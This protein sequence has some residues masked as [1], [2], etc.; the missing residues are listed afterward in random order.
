LIL[1][2]T[3]AKNEIP[4]HGVLIDRRTGAEVGP[5]VP[6]DPRDWPYGTIEPSEIL[7]KY[8]DLWKF[9]EM[10]ENSALYFSRQDRFDDPFEGRFT[11]ANATGLSTTEQ[12]FYNAYPKISR[13]QSEAKKQ[14]ETHRHC[15][16]ISCWHRN[17]KESQEMWRAYTTGP[18]SVVVT[19]SA[20]ALYR[21][22][23]DEIMK[24]PVKYH[25]NNY[26]RSEIFGWNTLSFYKPS[27]H[28]FE[29]E[30]RML[31]NLGSGESVSW[32]DPLD[33]GR[34]VKVRLNR[35]VH[36]VIVHPKSSDTTKQKIDFLLKQHLKAVK[37]EFSCHA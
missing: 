6:V 36:R 28:G 37:L 22:L 10:L 32:D 34:Y 31:R 21:F 17:T 7:W 2:K 5:R 25:S 19:T 8:M 26:R 35:I 15:V 27:S 1:K 12:A 14:Y 33:Y 4:T 3:S 9:K 23:P 30:F 24:S 20:K 18:E 16:F 11:K 29:R 13:S